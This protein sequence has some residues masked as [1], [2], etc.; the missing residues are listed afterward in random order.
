MI[1]DTIQLQILIRFG[2]RNK[3]TIQEKHEI[4]QKEVVILI[5]QPCT[6]ISKGTIQVKSL[7]P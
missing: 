2:I 5:H 4:Y 6:T 3:R 1:D 7:I